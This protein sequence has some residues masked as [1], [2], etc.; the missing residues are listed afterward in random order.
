MLSLK[1]SLLDASLPHL[2][3]S[4]KKSLDP[5][6]AQFSI[7]YWLSWLIQHCLYSTQLIPRQ[8]SLVNS[9]SA[10]PATYGC[11]ALLAQLPTNGPLLP[12]HLTNSSNPVPF[13]SST[14]DQSRPCQC[15]SQMEH[16][17]LATP[18]LLPACRQFGLTS[19]C[20]LIAFGSSLEIL[21]AIGSS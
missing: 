20:N 16:C 14:I 21:I 18:P 12:Y 1:F 3:A 8:L 11:P 10:N 19:S 13:L 6:L 17:A 2:I 15:I 7:I 9:A 4:T 5:T